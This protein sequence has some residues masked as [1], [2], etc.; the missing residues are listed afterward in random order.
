MECHRCMVCTFIY[1]V[2]MTVVPS[3]CRDDLGTRCNIYIYIYVWYLCC[4]V[5]MPMAGSSIKT[6]YSVWNCIWEWVSCSRSRA[7][8]GPLHGQFILKHKFHSQ[9]LT[10]DAEPASSHG[11]VK[12]FWLMLLR[13]NKNSSLTGNGS[14]CTHG[15]GGCVGRAHT[16]V[17]C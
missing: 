16:N 8:S 15:R 11:G 2:M 14:P 1:Y 6:N 7:G 17:E 9:P 3:E 10:H 13:G 12:F 4:L 5:L